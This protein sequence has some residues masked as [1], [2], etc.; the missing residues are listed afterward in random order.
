MTKE[1]YQGMTI[2]IKKI[3]DKW[4]VYLDG[5]RDASFDIKEDAKSYIKLCI[6]INN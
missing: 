4:I 2:E 6:K 3:K 5:E 1:F